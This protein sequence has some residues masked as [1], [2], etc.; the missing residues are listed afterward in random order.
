MTAHRASQLD[1]IQPSLLQSSATKALQGPPRAGNVQGKVARTALFS[2][3]MQQLLMDL[4]TCSAMGQH[5]PWDLGRGRER[6]KFK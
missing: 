3:E 4:P 5:T 2:H 6:L 1:G